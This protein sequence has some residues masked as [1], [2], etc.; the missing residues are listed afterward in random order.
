MNMNNFLTRDERILLAL[1]IIILSLLWILISFLSLYS[2]NQLK[3]VENLIFQN[4]LIKDCLNTIIIDRSKPIAIDSRE[5]L[6]FHIINKF[7]LNKTE[8][9]SW[10]NKKRSI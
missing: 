2:Q 4:L 6:Y 7:S 3:T 8:K 10:L 1:S 9:I 5:I